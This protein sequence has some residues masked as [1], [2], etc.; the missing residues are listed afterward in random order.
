MSKTFVTKISVKKVCGKLTPP[1]E[2]IALM[3]VFGMATEMKTGESNYGP[4]VALLG[5]FR[6]IRLTDGEVFES[7]TCHLPRLAIELVTPY[8]KKEGVDSLEFG[9]IIGVVPAENAYGYEFY[10]ESLSEPS[11]SDALEVLAKRVSRASVSTLP[12]PSKEPAVS[13]VKPQPTTAEKGKR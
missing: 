12:A 8:L 4:W 1:T 6:A 3:E 13:I 9:F 5:R 10:A 2:K 11:E 7:G